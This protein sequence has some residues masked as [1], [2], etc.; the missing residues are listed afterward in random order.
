MNEDKRPIV[1]FELDY[2]VWLRRY[3]QDRLVYDPKGI[4]PT[5]L[6]FGGGGQETKIIE[7]G[8][9]DEQ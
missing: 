3:R 6:T 5:V 4:A 2:G 9:E 7:G 8:M 1:V